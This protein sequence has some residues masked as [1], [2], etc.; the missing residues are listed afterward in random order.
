MNYVSEQERNERFKTLKKR[1]DN[2]KCFDCSD[3]QPQWAT[4]SF[5]ILL[6]LD[7]SAKHRSYGPNISFVRSATMDNWR[8]GELF[9]MEEGGNKGFKEYLKKHGVTKVDYAGEVAQGYKGLLEQRVADAFKSSSTD[10]DDRKE[11]EQGNKPAVVVK[12]K[13]ES[14]QETENK[15]DYESKKFQSKAVDSKK[16]DEQKEVAKPKPKKKIG[17]GG[18]KITHD[19]DFNSLVVD[20][21]QL[22]DKPMPQSEETQKFALKKLDMAKKDEPAQQQSRQQ[23]QATAKPNIDKFKNYTGIGSDMLETEQSGKANIKAFNIKS[24]FGSDQLNGDGVSDDQGND[25][26]DTP[27]VYFARKVGSKVR[28]TTSNLLTN[29]KDKMGK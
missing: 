8:E 14:K 4:V 13:E 16:A 25:T 10:A 27:F 1:P 29:I 9:V 24:G 7:C 5:G 2:Q 17:L 20:D 18:K 22:Q 21:L 12:A 3:K 23:E 26:V 6:C 19:V 11:T 15:Y 28:N